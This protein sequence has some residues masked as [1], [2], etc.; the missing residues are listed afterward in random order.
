[1]PAIFSLARRPGTIDHENVATQGELQW[2]EYVSWA[3]QCSEFNRLRMCRTR[4]GRHGNVKEEE[5]RI[6]GRKQ[7]DWTLT[8]DIADGLGR[9]FSR[10]PSLL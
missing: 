6:T 3:N 1:M 8:F 2:R 9:R 4:N 7:K 5:R 10:C